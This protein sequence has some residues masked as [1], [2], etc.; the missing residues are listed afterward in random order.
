MRREGWV[1]KRRRRVSRAVAISAAL[2]ATVAIGT[3][4]PSVQ[5]AG[6]ST[7]TTTVD[8][9]WASATR[10]FGGSDAYL[11]Q[12]VAGVGDVSGDGW[13]DVAVGLEPR[14]SGAQVLDGVHVI[15]GP[16]PKGRVAPRSLSGFRIETAS[17]AKYYNEQPV[18]GVAGAG[19]VNGDGL[20]DLAITSSR[21]NNNS[22]GQRER[23]E[24]SYVVFGSHSTHPVRLE[25]LGG[26]GFQIRGALNR[27]PSN[28]QVSDV[29]AQATGIGD[30][31]GD[32]LADIAIRSPL[33]SPAGRPG[34]GVIYVVLGRRS[35]GAVDVHNLGSGGFRVEGADADHRIGEL[36]VSGGDVNGDG[37]SDLI[38][39]SSDASFI[40]YLQS[41]YVLFGGTGTVPVNLAN[42]DARGF[43]IDGV[44]GA[45]RASAAAVG[46]MNGDGRSEVAVGPGPGE[47]AYVVF[48][49]S[50]SSPI[51]VRR[52]ENAGFVI[53]AKRKPP[54]EQIFR[55]SGVAA[56]G[57]VNGDG[58]A[59]VLVGGSIGYLIYG[60]QSSRTVDVD[61]LGRRGY[62]IRRRI[63]AGAGAVFAAAGDQNGDRRADLLFGISIG[64]GFR[65][66]DAGESRLGGRPP[67]AGGGS[68]H[69]LRG[70]ARL[71]HPPAYIRYTRRG[72]RLRGGRSDDVIFG[73]G[74]NDLLRGRS[75]NDCLIGG[76]NDS[77]YDN[78]FLRAPR[79]DRD[80]IYGGDGE[81]SLFGAIETDRLIGGDGDDHLYGGSPLPLPA[82]EA[83]PVRRPPRPRLA[84]DVLRGGRGDDSLFGESGNDRLYGGPGNDRITGGTGEV[85]VQPLRGDGRDRIFGGLGDDFIDSQDAEVDIVDCGPGTDTVD[86]DGL[87]R[88]FGCEHVK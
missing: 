35:T 56:A 75:G 25:E 65:C 80:R 9:S 87:D 24:E 52:V 57:D 38:I 50:E 88:L 84:R 12:T 3:L 44:I 42:L 82:L 20:A 30:I 13:P 86:T 62:R 14:P 2:G 36:G 34:A 40:P 23:E 1:G 45:G 32:R 49:R 81:D 76:E 28:G 27:T 63:P 4:A 43:Q 51:D 68:V 72:D 79:P 71:P 54:P 26:R 73:D 5:A 29:F 22:T 60:S 31:N 58:R 55:L 83:R 37:R 16:L 48:G 33:E 74:G 67:L 64:P 6:K 46:D 59:D 77:G 47:R 70:A 66:E 7:R 69:L 17:A 11:G 53:R 85:Q 61:A 21:T 41:A 8:L 78:T 15:F 10:L 19:D 39:G 18:M